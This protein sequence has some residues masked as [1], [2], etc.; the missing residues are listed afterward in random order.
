[1]LVQGATSGCGRT[2][3][4]G[5]DPVPG[6]GEPPADCQLSLDATP[7]TIPAAGGQV[8][9]KVTVAQG[10]AWTASASDIPWLTGV[11]ASGSGTGQF[12][13]SA[14][15]NVGP[16]RTAII[17]VNDVPVTVTQSG[18][19]C[20]GTVAF[21][22][23]GAMFTSAGGSGGFAVDSAAEFCPYTLNSSVSWISLMPGPGFITMTVSGNT[24]A[25]RIGTVTIGTGTAMVAQNAAG[26]SCSFLLSST[27]QSLPASGGRVTVSVSSGSGCAWA[28]W[29]TSMLATW[30]AFEGTASG[31][32]NGTVSFTVAPNT[33]GPRQTTLSIAGV[34]FSLTQS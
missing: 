29:R 33:G 30:V 2:S 7:S 4:T 28:A 21:A 25:A 8:T 6:D 19:T 34:S 15:L 14:A 10:C 12:N 26:A 9:I 23:G 32:G 22:P 24:G 20:T 27:F 31:I 13:A 17:T 11:T 1:M 5:P 3:P 16:P 18:I